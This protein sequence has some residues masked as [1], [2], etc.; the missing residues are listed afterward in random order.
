[1]L[2][3]ISTPPREESVISEP[4]KITGKRK[5]PESEVYQLKRVFVKTEEKGKHTMFESYELKPINVPTFSKL[6]RGVTSE[7]KLKKEDDYDY[8]HDLAILKAI[9]HFY[10][11]HGVIPHSPYSKNFIDYIE[12][13]IGE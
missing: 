5:L 3:P 8:N 9:F 2:T 4:A 13:S 10:F 11:N 12:V 7:N 6:E 1:M